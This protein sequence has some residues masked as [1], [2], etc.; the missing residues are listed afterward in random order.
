M[1][2]LINIIR[3]GDRSRLKYGDQEHQGGGYGS[4][5]QL[6]RRPGEHDK[7]Q[8]L[9]GNLHLDA[10]FVFPAVC[11]SFSFWLCFPSVSVCCFPSGL[12]VVLW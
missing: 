7:E 6:G 3:S 11:V 5:T 10:L 2:E 1:S 9:G 12:S 8:S 4:A